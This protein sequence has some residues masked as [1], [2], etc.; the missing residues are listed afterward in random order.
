[1][2]TEKIAKYI[3]LFGL[4]FFYWLDPFS[5]KSFASI[6][7]SDGWASCLIFAVAECWRVVLEVEAVSA[8]DLHS[9]EQRRAHMSVLQCVGLDQP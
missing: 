4:L 8:V 2:K 1:M 5:I 3:E 7:R 9:V 6:L